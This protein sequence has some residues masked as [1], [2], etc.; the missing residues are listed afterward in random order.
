MDPRVIT[1]SQKLPPEVLGLM[2]QYCASHVDPA[3]VGRLRLLSNQWLNGVTCFLEA[4]LNEQM[5]ATT[6]VLRCGFD[7]QDC[8]LFAGGEGDDDD[9]DAKM[10]V[11]TCNRFMFLHLSRFSPTL[12]GQIQVI[13]SSQWNDFDD[14]AASLFMKPSREKP[15]PFRLSRLEE[16][17]HVLR[18]LKSV[19]LAETKITDVTGCAIGR[20]LQGLQGLNLASCNITDLTVVEISSTCSQ[21]QRLDLS[22]CSQL[23]ARSMSALA[24]LVSLTS[25]NL[26]YCN[27]AVSGAAALEL[28]RLVNLVELNLTSCRGLDDKAI[29]VLA[30]L[31][32]LRSLCLE[33]CNGHL[34][35][36]VVMGALV[37]LH[38]LESL[39]LDMCDWVSDEM[40]QQLV[41]NPP[42]R[43][44]LR[45]L[46]LRACKKVT[47]RGVEVLA[48]LPRL[49]ELTL[50]QCGAL[51]AFCIG[52]LTTFPAV[53]VL[54]LS[55]CYFLGENT[56][57][58]ALF[59]TAPKLRSL[60]LHANSI[61]DDALKAFATA[62]SAK[63]SSSCLQSLNLS[64]NEDLS[65]QGICSLRLVPTL[66]QLD[67][68][69]CELTKKEVDIVRQQLPFV[70]SLVY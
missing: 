17:Q 43:N 45:F 6:W 9:D 22:R 63:G 61:S 12:L 52:P 18:G 26:S 44:S 64:A 20:E 69:C 21:L 35:A 10:S 5:V 24:N 8:L 19:I 14:T 56:K 68:S 29:E 66:R 38:S 53:E 59:S 49:A 40:L 27:S 15:P 48:Q 3:T 47:D 57:C 65:V 4:L 60:D 37:G 62:F 46:S 1:A 70:S 58:V 28:S 55:A 7:R 23:T 39:G 50:S 51:S 31:T 25:L 13:D 16:L 11:P 42:V 33:K 54:N 41:S 34:T 2:I 36:D 32:A 67:I 30:S